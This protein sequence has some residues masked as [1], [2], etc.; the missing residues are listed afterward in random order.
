MNKILDGSGAPAAVFALLYSYTSPQSVEYYIREP[1]VRV[2]VCSH[3]TNF[4]PIFSLMKMGFLATN[5]DV[6]TLQFRSVILRAQ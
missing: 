1:F 5:G 3:V 4:R 6:H 2:G